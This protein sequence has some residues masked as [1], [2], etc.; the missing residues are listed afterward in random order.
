MTQ[1]TG[2]APQIDRHA[3]D[4]PLPEPPRKTDIVHWLRTWTQVLVNC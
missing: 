4:P 1:A 3:P 2:K